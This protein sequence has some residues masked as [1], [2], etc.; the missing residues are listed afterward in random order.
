VGLRALI[1]DMDGLLFDT[2]RLAISTWR[3]AGRSLGIELAEEV[4][5]GT[6]GLDHVLTRSY[7][8]RLFAGEFP[9]DQ[10]EERHRELFR[11]RIVKHGVPLK[12]GVEQILQ[13]AGRLELRVALGTS[14]RAVYA[15]TML[16]LAG[17]VDHFHV[18][19]TRDLVQAGKPAPD[20]F[21]K[22]ASLLHNE[23]EDCLVLEDSPN[24]I[25]AAQAARM[26]VIM[27]PD[28]IEPTEELRARCLA[29]YPS[30][31][32]VAR[33]LEGMIHHP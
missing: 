21:L 27:V 18:L 19:V 17:I 13:E 3:E 11:A 5:L 33:S 15:H 6:I 24:G 31:I 2:E 29:V 14:S 32:E 16:W 8:D 7:Y 28:L 9:Y 4:V 23:P 30:L 12:P 22:A 26:R 10:V 20:I 25:K 1:F